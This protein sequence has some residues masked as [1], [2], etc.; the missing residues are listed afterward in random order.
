MTTQRWLREVASRPSITLIPEAIITH[1]VISYL[2]EVEAFKARGA[3]WIFYKAYFL[4]D[5]PGFGSRPLLSCFDHYHI[6]CRGRVWSMIRRG[7]E[8]QNLKCMGVRAD[9]TFDISLLSRL[10]GLEDLTI[11]CGK[12]LVSLHAFPKNLVKLTKL[13]IQ[14]SV[15]DLS[16]INGCI[17]LKELHLHS[18]KIFQPHTIPSTLSHLKLLSLVNCGMFDLSFL[19][20]LCRFKNLTELN[21]SCNGNLELATIPNNLCQVLKKLDVCDCNLRNVSLLGR[22]CFLEMLDLSW[23][24]DLE[25]D[26]FPNC[27]TRLRT[28]KIIDC[29]LYK[30]EFLERIPE[31]EELT[32]RTENAVNL[33]SVPY[34]LRKLK[35]LTMELLKPEVRKLSVL[36]RFPN[37]TEL[38]INETTQIDLSSIPTNLWRLRK[39]SLTRSDLTDFSDLGRLSNL[40]ECDLSEN[41]KIIIESLP[42]NLTHLVKLTLRYC[43]LSDISS[44]SQFPALEELDLS[45]NPLKLERVPESFTKIRKIWI[46][47]DKVYIITGAELIDPK[48]KK[49]IQN[50]GR[51]AQSYRFN[52]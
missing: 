36:S 33:E 14:V 19:S 48:N 52:F 39:L 51:S 16:G 30:L 31:L 49:M 41:K 32:I 28:L 21:L 1:L 11:V 22:L 3:C 15:Q 45:R 8:Y 46:G 34:N 27:L 12:T 17:G 2:T 44:F 47:Q 26:T 37:L 23:N 7:C 29:N 18:N 43:N 25:L 50:Y 5:Y 42:K 24:Q 10:P 6:N 40:E 9:S 38:K 4:Q 35:I 13:K 20:S